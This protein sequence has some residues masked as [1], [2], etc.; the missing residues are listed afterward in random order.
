MPTR[1]RPAGGDNG[2]EAQPI[3]WRD[4]VLEVMKDTKGE[5]VRLHDIYPKVEQNPEAVKRSQTN[6]NIRPKIRQQLQV[7]V[8]DNLVERLAPGEYRFLANSLEERSDAST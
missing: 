5:V 3:R 1:R 8:R 2:R 6:V 7:L 4:I